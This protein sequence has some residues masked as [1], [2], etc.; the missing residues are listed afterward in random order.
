[1]GIKYKICVGLLVLTGVLF[2]LS[3]YKE[4]KAIDWNAYHSSREQRMFEYDMQ[5][6]REN[7]LEKECMEYY[8]N[9]WKEESEYKE[10]E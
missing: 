1:M 3:L 6:A 10:E 9:K 5:V 4:Y 7:G 8:M 2:G